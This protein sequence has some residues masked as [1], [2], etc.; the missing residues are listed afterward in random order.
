MSEV[1]KNVYI[2][3][4]LV[5]L[6]FYIIE[7]GLVL[8]FSFLYYILSD[9]LTPIVSYNKLFLLLSKSLSFIFVFKLFLKNEYST[10]NTKVKNFQPKVG[11]I[12]FLISIGIVLINNP[13]WDI[14]K[15]A[16]FIR[17]KTILIDNYPFKGFNMLFFLNIISGLFIAPIVEEL[18]FRKYLFTIILKSK[19]LIVA[20][21]FSNVLFSL[22]HLPTYNNLIPTFILGLVSCIIYYRTKNIL[23]SILMHFFYNLIIQI[24]NDYYNSFYVFIYELEFNYSYWLAVLFG[25]FL[26]FFSLKKLKSITA[27]KN[28]PYHHG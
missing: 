20:T 12:V 19:T 24:T 7:S 17:E 11:L 22:I 25:V 21:G 9:N 2:K 18:F 3:T 13:F 4:I 5:L 14:D 10:I 23:Y 8:L 6:I 1:L 27:L 16:F 26:T 28:E 15:I